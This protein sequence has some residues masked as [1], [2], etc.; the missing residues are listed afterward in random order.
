MGGTPTIQ[1]VTHIESYVSSSSSA[2]QQA[3]S[4]DAIALLV[5]ND[6]LSL[7]T[8]VR[9]MEMYLTTTDSIIRAR[10]ILLLGEL[11][12]RLISKPLVDTAISSLI[13]FFT[14]RLIG[15]RCVVPLSVVWLY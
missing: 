3:A 12:M 14:E 15:R 5:K 10:G 6:L 7:E 9:E 4:I 2:A 8:L 11:L 13:E 1:Y